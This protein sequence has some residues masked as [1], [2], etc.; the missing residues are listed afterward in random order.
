MKFSILV[1]LLC[2][3]LFRLCNSSCN[4]K[5]HVLGTGY[6]LSAAVP[7]VTFMVASILVVNKLEQMYS[8]IGDGE[9]VLFFT[10]SIALS[11]KFQ[12]NILI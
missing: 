8:A 12:H 6:V 5:N 11:I 4:K 2:S 1:P 3:C 7:A 10:L 9:I